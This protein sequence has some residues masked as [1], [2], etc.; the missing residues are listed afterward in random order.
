MSPVLTDDIVAADLD[1]VSAVRDAE[2]PRPLTECEVGGLRFELRDGTDDERAGVYYIGHDK[3]GNPKPALWLCSPLRIKAMTRGAKSSEWG[4]LLEWEDADGVRH[5]WAM[6]MELLQGDGVD[7]RRELSRLGLDIAPGRAAREMLITYLQAWPVLARARCVDQLGWNGGVYVRPD[8][9]VG[10]NSERTV[11]Q[12]MQ[13]L[14]PALSVMGTAAQWRDEVAALAAGNSRLMF[15]LACAFAGPLLELAGEDS[16]GFHLRGPSSC[17]KSTALAVAASIWG[18][19]ADYPR[20]WRTTANGL[21]GLAAIHNHGLLILDELSQ[22]DPREAGDAAYML[23]N[24]QG[25]TRASRTGSAR[26]AA[27]WKLLFLSAGEV[28]LSALMAQ[29]GKKTNAGQEIRLADIEADAGAGHGLFDCLNG[30]TSAPALALA[31]KEACS[32]RY[33]AVGLE[34][35]H[36]VVANRAALVERVAADVRAF[37]AE[38]V[39][40]G[41]AGQIVRVAR[42]FGLVAVAGELATEYGLT[43]WEKGST[44]VGVARCFKAWLES[45]GGTGRREDRA[46]LTQVRAFFGSHGAS[47]FQEVEALVGQV[48][49]RAGFVRMVNGEQEFFVLPEVFKKEVCAGFDPKWAAQV[50]VDAGVLRPG[51]GGK[52]STTLTPAAIGRKVRVY[53]FTAEVME[54]VD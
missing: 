14:E 15:A 11:F 18:S 35:L 54:E 39:P 12:S 37:V 41:A 24:G 7:V 52:N 23:G 46:L 40:E 22:V 1:K 6:P 42:R 4:R 10:S 31:L 32:C 19:P 34:W 17:G 29:A 20:M 38:H 44:S 33:G 16:G 25:K 47:R 50:L 27:R 21:E 51:A 45:F 28:S 26:L 48:R 36:K 8:Q 5:V 9:V 43:G 53:A 3:D 2:E 13:T 49:D 30:Q